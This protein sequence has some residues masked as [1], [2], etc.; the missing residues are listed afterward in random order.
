MLPVFDVRLSVTFHL[1]FG[2]IILVRFGFLS[3]HLWE[4]AAH[5]VDH[6]SAPGDKASN[7]A[8]VV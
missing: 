8:I 5:S 2:H 7:N 6:M 4:R 3:G 1:M